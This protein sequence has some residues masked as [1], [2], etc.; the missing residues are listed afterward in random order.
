MAKNA[1]FH[2]SSTITS[3]VNQTL[4]PSGIVVVNDGSSDATGEILNKATREHGI[5]VVDR[6]DMG[7]DIRRVPSN[8]NLAI[9]SARDLRTDYLMISGD[10]CTY[11]AQYAESLVR[12]MDQNVK[13]VVASGR[14]SHRGAL[15]QEH[16]PSG[17]GRVVR[18]SFLGSV[19]NRFPIKAGWEAWL[20]YQ[21]E[22]KGLETKLFNDLVYEHVRPRGTGHQFT[23]WGAAM[24]TLG[25]HPLYALGRIVRNLVKTLSL[26]SSLGLLRGYVAGLLGSSDPFMTRFNSSICEFVHAQQKKEIVRTIHS[27]HLFLTRFP[28]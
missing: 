10:D 13:I 12:E 5:R 16:S 2:I 15:S 17:S 23:Y 6:P 28:N 7:Y 22:Q 4:K 3:L 19:G 24:Y 18:A 14:P 26:K 25:Y 9:E 1:A 21:A 27:I 11:P 20:L 8:I